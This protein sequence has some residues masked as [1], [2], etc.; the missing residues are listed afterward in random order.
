MILKLL[1]KTGPLAG[2]QF[3]LK[4]GMVIG[5]S[6]VDITLDDAKLSGRH[7]KVETDPAGNW[8]MIDLGSTNGL[9]VKGKRLAQV[10]LT[11]GT[12]IHI[13][14]TDMEVI[15]AP[16]PGMASPNTATTK[17]TVVPS[18]VTTVPKASV[19]PNLSPK[20]PSA[21]NTMA[22]P[23]PPLPEHHVTSV[24]LAPISPQEES[25]APEEPTWSEYLSSFSTRAQTK[26][27]NDSKPLK[28]FDPMLVLTVVRGPQIGT[29]WVLGYGPRSVGLDSV[30]L[31]LLDS[32]A[33]G[34]AFVVTPKGPYAVFETPNSKK[35]RLNNKSISS[36]TLR[37]DDKITVGDTVIH[38]SYRE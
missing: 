3:D 27:R 13:G 17:S 8:I 16:T 15:S 38:V 24:E 35:V 14:N 26:V 6:S 19:P 37:G 34:T 5:R 18:K 7:A 21:Q 28:P 23:L 22:P 25:I 2:K 32:H 12:V 4:A 36:E 29:T 10:S 1:V 9:K 33:P 11:P 30:D 31:P 20:K